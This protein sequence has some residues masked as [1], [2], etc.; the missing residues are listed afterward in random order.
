M[1]VE[2][3]LLLVTLAALVWL[4]SRWRHSYWSSKGVASPPALPFIGHFH[5]EYFMHAQGV[6][7][8]NEVMFVKCIIN[9]QYNATLLY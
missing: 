9:K 5:K 8:I 7:F 6:D 3:L 2:A 4:Y 1:A